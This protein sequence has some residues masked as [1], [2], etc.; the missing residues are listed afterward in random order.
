M[1]RRASVGAQQQKEVID[2][3]EICDYASKKPA[4]KKVTPGHP[5]PLFTPG[6]TG[7]W[8][9]AVEAR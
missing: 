9:L 8:Q 6:Q 1:S 3:V 2:G 7:A 4:P 5:F